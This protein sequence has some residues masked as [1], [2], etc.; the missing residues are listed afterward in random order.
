MNKEVEII[1]IEIIGKQRPSAFDRMWDEC[2]WVA[3]L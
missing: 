2:E 3:I 1:N